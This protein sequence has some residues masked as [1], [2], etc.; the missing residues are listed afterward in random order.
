MY[1]IHEFVNLRCYT[2]WGKYMR[3]YS[4]GMH[5]LLVYIRI[6]EITH[7]K[8][9]RPEENSWFHRPSI[10]P[11]TDR[12]FE[13]KRQV[14]QDFFRKHPAASKTFPILKGFKILLTIPKSIGDST[15]SSTRY[16]LGETET[17]PLFR[18]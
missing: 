18:I 2:R 3:D 10:R 9:G 4:M 15:F 8:I 14:R 6:L 1:Q 11:P 7:I 16:I 12:H 17:A 13:E 5:A